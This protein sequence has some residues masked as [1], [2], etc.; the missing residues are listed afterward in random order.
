MMSSRIVTG[1]VLA[2]V[3]PPLHPP[4]PSS[5]HARRA[6]RQGIAAAI[7]AATAVATGRR[8]RWRTPRAKA[9]APTSRSGPPKAAPTTPAGRSRAD[10][11][12]ARRASTATRPA[13]QRRAPGHGAAGLQQRRL[14][15]G[16]YQRRYNNGALQQRREP[17]APRAY[18]NRRARLQRLVQLFERLATRPAG[19]RAIAAATPSPTTRSP[20]TRRPYYYHGYRGVYGY[21]GSYRHTRIVTVCPWRPYYYR[22]HFSIGVYYG[23]GGVYDYGY[24]PSYYYDPIPGPGL[25]RRAHHGSAA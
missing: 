18:S 20:T 14:Q 11:R 10:S 21:G 3:L 9:P 1:A 7:A 16:G 25:R 4:W 6:T 15:R 23:A 8:S 12:T 19:R 17:T 24:T 5:A 22:P 13:R 2:G